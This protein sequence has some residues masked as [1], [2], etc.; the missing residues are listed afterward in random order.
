[1]LK[2]QEYFGY[3]PPK[4]PSSSSPMRK[5]HLTMQRLEHKFGEEPDKKFNLAKEFL[6]I[7]GSSP[8]GQTPRPSHPAPKS[9]KTLLM[10]ACNYSHL[11]RQYAEQSILADIQRKK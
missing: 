1:M 5:L 7:A 11:N 10:T 6:E 9:D 8:L 3:N 2:L 4:E